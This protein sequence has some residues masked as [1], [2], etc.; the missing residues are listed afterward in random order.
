MKN[1]ESQ[2]LKVKMNRPTIQLIQKSVNLQYI[3]QVRV[4]MYMTNV[5]LLSYLST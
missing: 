1:K 3:K 2:H 5:I 4:Y